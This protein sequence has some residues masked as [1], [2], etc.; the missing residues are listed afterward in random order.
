[1]NRHN[2]T[3]ADTA[4]T[5]R[6]RWTFWVFLKELSDILSGA[7]QAAASDRELRVRWIE[8]SILAGLTFV[9]FHLLGNTVSEIQ[10]RSVFVWMV[11]RWSDKISFGT[12][13]SHGWLIP[14]VSI[15]ALWHRREA[16]RRAQ[17]NPSP[18]GLIV[19]ASALL[20]HWVGARMQQPRVSLMAFI[21][22]PWGF[23]LYFHGLELARLLTFPCAYLAFC[24]P[25]NFL[26]ALAFPLRTFAANLSALTLNGLGIEAVRVGSAIYSSA[27]GGFNFDVADPCSGL[28]SLLAMVSLVAAYAF[29]TQKGIR[30]WILF[31]LSIPIAVFG[32]VVRI[33]SIG[34]FA[35]GFGTEVALKV[36]HDYSGYIIFAGSTLL[37]LAVARVINLNVRQLVHEH[38]RK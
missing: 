32:N 27:G 23:A 29:F 24:I 38:I 28:R 20:L 6:P 9:M 7:W 13:Y 15:A 8:A 16:I 12:D 2:T 31:F 21:A 36:Y 17:S 30:Q 5:K 33:V 3:S 25:L 34:L 1:M 10:H 14:L 26:D 4:G 18:M 19:I 35:V 11:A 22:L 37:M